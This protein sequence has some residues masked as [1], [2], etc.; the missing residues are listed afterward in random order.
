MPVRFLVG[1]PIWTVVCAICASSAWMLSDSF[2]TNGRVV[3]I[4]IFVVAYSYATSTDTFR[5]RMRRP[6]EWTAFAIAYA[7]R[8]LLSLAGTNPRQPCFIG[9][10]YVG[11]I[12]VSMVESVTG[13]RLQSGGDFAHTL[14]ITLVHGSAISA[15]TFLFYLLLR[16]FTG[17]FANEHDQTGPRGFE[18]V[19]PADTKNTEARDTQ[20][21]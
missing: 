16:F 14:A 3:G 12:S 11:M 1:L 8:M 18:V 19:M 6:G 20:T 5:M 4:A 2:S 17:A 13:T 9:D 21:R 10:A 7:G 15:I